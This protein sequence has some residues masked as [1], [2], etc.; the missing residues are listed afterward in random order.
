MQTSTM[1]QSYS[2]QIQL[3]AFDVEA[4]EKFY[5][6]FIDIVFNDNNDLKCTLLTNN[7]M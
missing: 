7:M 3:Y 5:N 2:M 1:W 4:D 6:K